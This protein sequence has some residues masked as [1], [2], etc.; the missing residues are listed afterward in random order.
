LADLP[1]RDRALEIGRGRIIREGGAVPLLCF[2]TRLAD[3]LAAADRLAAMGLS[4][5]VADARFAQPLDTLR[6][7]Q[8]ARHHEVLVTAEEAAS[9]TSVRL[10]C[11]IW[12]DRDNLTAASRSAR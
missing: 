10:S 8:R 7:D 5:T 1:S 12:P 9:P 2:G 4:A 11:L 6:I 3:C